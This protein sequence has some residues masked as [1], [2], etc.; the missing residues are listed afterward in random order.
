[1]AKTLS[2]FSTLL[3]IIILIQP[4]Q[5]LWIVLSFEMNREYIA[6]NLCENKEAEE[7]RLEELTRLRKA[8]AFQEQYGIRCAGSCQLQKRLAE[9]EKAAQETSPTTPKYALDVLFLEQTTFFTFENQLFSS[10]ISILN[11]FYRGF[12]STSIVYGIFRPPVCA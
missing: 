1:M 3:I 4:F 2:I 7:K 8:K 11:G 9:A 5:K 12:V 10:E 6:Q